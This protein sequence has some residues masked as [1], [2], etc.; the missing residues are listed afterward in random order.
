MKI[1]LV[2]LSMLFLVGCQSGTLKGVGHTVDGVLEDVQDGI[3]KVRDAF[4]PHPPTE[5]GVDK[6]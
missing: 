6:E 1:F 5:P 4:N 2:S 3:Q